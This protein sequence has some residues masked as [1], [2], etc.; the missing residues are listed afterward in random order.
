MKRYIATYFVN[1]IDHN[2]GNKKLRLHNVSCFFLQPTHRRPSVGI[3]LATP[4][5]LKSQPECLRC[6]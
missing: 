5:E 4:E 1:G 2:I 6:P 3:R